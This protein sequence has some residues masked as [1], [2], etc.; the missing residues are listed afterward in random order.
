MWQRHV[1]VGNKELRAKIEGALRQISELKE[2]FSNVTIAAV[3]FFLFLDDQERSGAMP[4]RY[5]SDRVTV[6]AR[7]REAL[8]YLE[9]W[10]TLLLE[11]FERQ[12]TNDP[13]WLASQSA[14][15]PEQIQL[16]IGIAGVWRRWTRK[17]E[18]PL[19]RKSRWI[20][21]LQQAHKDIAQ[22]EIGPD[23]ARKLTLRATAWL[24]ER[25][26]SSPSVEN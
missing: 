3:S 2:F 22:R 21:F 14:A 16:A 20:R 4:S 13:N 12:A 11:K 7:Q 17:A 23:A 25:K 15:D 24:L 18:L 10:I 9:D 19:G 6:L 5:S 26:I 1:A 8:C